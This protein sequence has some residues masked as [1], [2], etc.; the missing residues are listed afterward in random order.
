MAKPN[1]KAKAAKTAHPKPTAKN[2]DAVAEVRN[3]LDQ[4]TRDWRLIGERVAEVG[5][6]YGE[7]K[8]GD[9]AKDVG[10]LPAP[11][12]IIAGSPSAPRR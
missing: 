11:C 4:H 5:K 2:D 12:G 10:L 1:G 8:V 6:A 9:F 7:D 3:I